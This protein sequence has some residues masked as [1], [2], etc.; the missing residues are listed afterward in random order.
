MM[1]KKLAKDYFERGIKRRKILNVL[2]EEND[3]PDVVREAQETVELILKGV[4]IYF[5]LEV[6]KLHDVGAIFK[7]NEDL[8]PEYLK[9]NIGRIQAISKELRRDR[10]LSFYGAE[11]IL[12][13]EYYTLQ[14]AEKVMEYVD[15]IIKIVN[16]VFEL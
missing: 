15:E 11:D 7:A 3:Y 1:T 9:S 13:S 14:D 5:G 2:T 6:P 16:K 4:L 12:P 10:E 8:F